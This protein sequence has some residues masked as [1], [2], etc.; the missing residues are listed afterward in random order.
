MEAKTVARAGYQGLLQG[1]HHCDSR[2]PQLAGCRIGAV[3]A[4]KDGDSSLALGIG[5]GGVSARIPRSTKALTP[6][7]STI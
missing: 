5:K 3:F 1:K 6:T 4:R 2:I 7:L